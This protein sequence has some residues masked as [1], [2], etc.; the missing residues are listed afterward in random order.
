MVFLLQ[1]QNLCIHKY[2]FKEC[3]Y[4][5]QMFDQCLKNIIKQFH[6]FLIYM[7]GF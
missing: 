2:T 3:Y 4:Q 1:E 5:V 6:N 7:Y